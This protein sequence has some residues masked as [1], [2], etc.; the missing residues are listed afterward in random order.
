MELVPCPISGGRD[1]TPLL[2][3]P[4][5]FD[6]RA[7]AWSIVRSNGSGLAMLNPRPDELKAAGHYP[8]EG[9]D[10]F[11]SAGSTIGFRDRAYLAAGEPLLRL[12]ASI[13]LAGIY[14]PPHETRILDVGCSGGRL[15]LHLHRRRGIPLGNLC[16]VEPDHG[17]R[18]AARSAGLAGIRAR[19]EDAGGLFDRIVFWHSLE[20]I[21]RIGDTLDA[22]RRLLAPDGM[23]VVALP[24]IGSRDAEAYGP[25]WVALDPPR[26]LWHFTPGTLGT[27]LSLH[28][29]TAETVEAYHPDALYNTWYSEKLRC[30]RAK[31][32][33]SAAG[34]LRAVAGAA[35]SMVEGFDPERASGFVCRASGK[36]Q[37][38]PSP[39]EILPSDR[40]ISAEAMR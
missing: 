22:A 2:D 20:H 34:A 35:A 31:L 18:E 24:N 14:K 29:F 9:Y 39:G 17:A 40:S 7:P 32:R 1:F 8:S 4:D 12:R 11:I 36:V 26:H 5:R 37:E 33:F 16:G 21:H 15:L 23:L 30:A 13:V 3:A 38:P 10:P 19:I 6:L 28:G 27:L 25:E